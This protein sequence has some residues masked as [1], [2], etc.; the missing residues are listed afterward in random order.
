MSEIIHVAPTIYLILGMVGMIVGSMGSIG[1]WFIEHDI[2][3][4]M[5]FWLVI[6]GSIISFL[7]LGTTY[8]ELVW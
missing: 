1:F 2:K 7:L 6:A 4:S 5:I 3:K 8:G